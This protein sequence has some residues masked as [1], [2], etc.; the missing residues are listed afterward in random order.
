MSSKKALPAWARRIR[1]ERRQRGWTQQQLAAH[2]LKAAGETIKMVGFESVIRRIKSHES[3]ENRPRD[4]YPLLYCRAFDI[5]EGKL[6]EAP[7]TP[8]AMAS[9]E[10]GNAGTPVTS[11]TLPWVWEAR[12]TDDAIYLITQDDL[13]LNRREAVKALA[14]TTGLPLVDPAQR[15]LAKPT[16]ELSLSGDNGRIGAD[17]VAQ[18]EAAANIFRTWDDQHGGGLARKAVIGQLNEVSDLVR[19]HHSQEI[20]I[21]LFHVMAQLSKIAATMSWDCGMQT[22]AQTYFVMS[23]QA[24]KTAGDRPFGASVLASMARQL[25]YLDQPQDALE[26]TRLA[27][28]GVRS[29]ATPRLRAMLHTREA[30][31][32]ARMGRSEAFKRATDA[33]EEAFNEAGSADPDPE[34]ITYFNAAELAGVTGGRYLELAKQDS[35]FA[36]RALSHIGLALELRQR[37]SMRSLALDQLGLASAYLLNGDLD[38]AVAVGDAAVDTAEKVQSDR[39]RVKLRELYR[40][41]EIREDPAV[42]PLREH[43]RNVLAR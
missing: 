26:L 27:L 38:Q 1:H 34:W 15:W 31:S 39:V 33:A 32:H 35:R 5:T 14:I 19:D 43:I 13:M 12:P 40:E 29:I 6:Y 23:L 21:R 10:V 4:P 8:I 25:L 9:G 42:A 7:V 36:G 11:P 24:S 22:A 20:R 3:G 16:P 28:D 18:L 2:L 37:S 30:W 41:I 17:E